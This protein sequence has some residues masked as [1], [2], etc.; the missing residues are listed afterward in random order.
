[1]YLSPGPEATKRRTL[2]I[3]I[4][5]PRPQQ[6]LRLAEPEGIPSGR[7]GVNAEPLALLDE[8]N[9]FADQHRE[10][11]GGTGRDRLEGMS[12]LG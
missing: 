11:P 4:G 8:S 12:F 9:Q 1:M 5:R 6:T 10:P 3:C 7:A 2:P